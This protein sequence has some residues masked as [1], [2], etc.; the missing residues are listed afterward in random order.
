MTM[1]C[2]R[3]GFLSM[4]GATAAGVA[5]L[6]ALRSSRAEPGAGAKARRLLVLNLVGAVRSSAAFHASS[7]QRYNP[8]G[9]ISGQSTP[10][11][12]G[13]LLDD[14]AADAAYTLGTAWQGARLPRLREIANQFSVLGTWSVTRGDHTRSRIEEPTGSATGQDPGLLTRVAAGLAGAAGRDL[15]IPPFHLEAATL[16][17]NS[18]G[19]LGRYAPVELASFES[20]PSSATEDARAQSRT[21]NRFA[22]NDAMR[23]RFDEPRVAARSGRGRLVAETYM[24]HKR[25]AR[26]VGVRLSQPD[27]AV[28]SEDADTAML[29]T[30][31]LASGNVP[32]TNAMLRE[33]MLSCVGPD[34]DGSPQRTIAIDAALAVRLLQLGSPAVVLEIADFDFHS[35][36]R[37]E[38]PPLYRFLGRLWA[39]LQ[40]LLSRIPD[41]SGEGTLLDRTLVTAFSDFGRDGVDGGW[42]GGEGS[43]H[44]VDASCFYLAHPVMGAGVK[45]NRLVGAVSTSHY[46]ARRE[47][48]QI[49]P[50]RYI[51]TLLGALGLD[52]ADPQF[53]FPDAGAPVME[54]WS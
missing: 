52:A 23:A 4:L 9:L 32:L 42:N 35:G 27:I 40:W 18:P 46:D 3:R 17:G 10:F 24:L 7:L 26:S 33:A 16:F 22:A 37:S 6:P 43:D 41:P 48:L 8:Y 28:G 25:A 36:E 19:A 53:G 1:T 44:G 5:F 29:G 51:A 13:S 45:P 39:T 15:D 50:Q 38:G 47:S 34:P 14:N 11:A 12:L 2:N 31:R 20:L 30:V 49:A 21:G 54:L